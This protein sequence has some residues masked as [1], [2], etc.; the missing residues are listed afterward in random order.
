MLSQ[1]MR[2]I[3]AAIDEA[4]LI[5]GCSSWALYKNIT[6]P[7][8]APAMATLGVLTF[9]NSW[10]DYLGPLVFMDSLRNYTL[11]VGIALYQSSYYTEYGRTLATSTLATLPLLLVFFAF[12]KQII[13]SMATT[14]LKD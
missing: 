1:F 14:G 5:D 6:L 2:V 13:E 8:C 11:P 10:N 7:L 12:Q 4:A 9:I 3:P